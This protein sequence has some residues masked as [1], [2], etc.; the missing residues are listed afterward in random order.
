MLPTLPLGVKRLRDRV[1]SARRP[2]GY[3]RKSWQ[4]SK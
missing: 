2:K 3:E 1:M 4:R